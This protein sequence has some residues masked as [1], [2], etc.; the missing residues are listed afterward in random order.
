MSETKESIKIKLWKYGLLTFVALLPPILSEVLPPFFE[1]E[2]QASWF[3]RSGSLMVII[4]AW[5]EFKLISISGYIDTGATYVVKFRVP[6][7]YNYW[8]KTI[9]LTT[10]LSMVAGTVIWGYGDL[11]F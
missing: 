11:L 2:S 1:S 5:V 6:I 10:I 7:S 9:S 8:Y 4:S 3:Q